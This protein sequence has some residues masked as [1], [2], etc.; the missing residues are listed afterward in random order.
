MK[1]VLI[2]HQKNPKT[3]PILFAVPDDFSVETINELLPEFLKGVA[4]VEFVDCD[5]CDNEGL[6]S[7]FLRKLRW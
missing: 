7:V 2:R 5:V 3:K 1:F 4:K 6:V